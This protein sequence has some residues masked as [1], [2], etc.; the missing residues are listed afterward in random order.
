M[1]VNDN[2]IS[3]SGAVV[4]IDVSISDDNNDSVE[5]LLDDDSLINDEPNVESDH[6][7]VDELLTEVNESDASSVN[8]LLSDEDSDS[9]DELLVDDGIRSNVSTE[10]VPLINPNP[11]A[12]PNVVYDI[13]SGDNSD[14]ENSYAE[15]RVES[16]DDTDEIHFTPDS[17]PDCLT[18][19]NEVTSETPVY[20]DEIMSDREAPEIVPA[21]VESSE[22][23]SK[24]S[25]SSVPPS[26]IILNDDNDC[27]IVEGV[28]EQEESSLP[29]TSMKNTHADNR[30]SCSEV[31]KNQSLLKRSFT[32][33]DIAFP[34]QS[35]NAD[36]RSDNNSLHN[37]ENENLTPIRK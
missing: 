34:D 26:L 20:W 32:S 17:E 23:G 2:N 13:S 9:V 14:G 33:L 15:I 31:I 24:S 28:I 7:S 11:V 6:D 22:A 27:E 36:E 8:V 10:T 21:L 30:P 12:M 29:L 18:R 35:S 1:A 16:S 37:G 19:L 5:E 3:T 25:A 4:P